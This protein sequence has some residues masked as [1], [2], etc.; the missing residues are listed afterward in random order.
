[1][2]NKN[3]FFKGI[4]IG[5]GKIIPGVS[6][7][8]IAV[9]L[10]V[11]DKMI[12]SISNIFVDFKNSAIFLFKIGLGIM[13][14]I[15]LMSKLLI[16]ALNNFYL[17][18]ILLFIGLIIGGIPQLIKTAKE[19]ISIINVGLLI[20]PLILFLVIDIFTSKVNINIEMNIFNMIWLGILEAISMI[21]PGI[22]GTAIMLMLGVY[23]GILNMFTDINKMLFLIFFIIGV[24][25]GVVLCSKIISRIL[26]KHK[27]SFYYL[28]I[29]FIFSSLLILLRQT[30]NF[31]G[32]PVLLFI[33]IIMLM[34]G[35]ISSY[36]L[37]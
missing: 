25:L 9:S 20:F 32:N 34:V 4:L 19:K 28:I 22:S 21:I 13:L 1:M 6:G 27:I 29:G 8:M 35:I 36:K 3:L 16:L 18:T 7:S 30:L 37:K 33:G 26:G 15:L 11:Y 2:K 23:E 17:P 5:L 12:N 24:L 31:D 14:S 10:G